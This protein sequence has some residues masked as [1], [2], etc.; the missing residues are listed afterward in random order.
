M[1]ATMGETTGYFAI[2]QMR[3]QMMSDAVGRMILK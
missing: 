3:K 1:V 2:V